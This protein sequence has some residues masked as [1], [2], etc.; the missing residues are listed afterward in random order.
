MAELNLGLDLGSIISGF[1][2]SLFGGLAEQDIL[3]QQLAASNA[4]KSK[5]RNYLTSGYD[6]SGYTSPYASWFDEMINTYGSGN[7]TKSQQNQITKAGAT[8]TNNINTVMSN[9]GGTIGG[10]L[11]ATEKLNENLADKQTEL[12]D[13]NV[14]TALNLANSR[15]TFNLSTF[16]QEQ[17]AK[18]KLAQ[19]LAQYS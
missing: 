8:G 18:N 3:D 19:L 13:E 10:Q 12:S 1:G 4:S 7:L 16:L 9:R 15:D 2:S 5:A 11:A 17:Q 14:N 6:T